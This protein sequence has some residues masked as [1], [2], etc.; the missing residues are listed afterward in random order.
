MP[1]LK[2]ARAWFSVWLRDI[3]IT[4][5]GYREIIETAKQMGL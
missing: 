2:L 3:L 5:G 4:E 1:G